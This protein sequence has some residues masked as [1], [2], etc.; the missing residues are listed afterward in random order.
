MAGQH[1]PT[2]VITVRK[3]G[4]EQQ[5]YLIFTMKDILVSSVSQS[6]GGDAPMEALS[7][8]F[9]SLK[10]SYHPQKPDGSLDKPVEETVS[11]KC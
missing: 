6:G 5:D 1:I 7:L 2:A 8:N 10:I 4:K 3:A 11:G 9:S